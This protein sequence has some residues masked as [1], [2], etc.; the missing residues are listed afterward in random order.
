MI[1]ITQFTLL[2]GVR[3]AVFSDDLIKESNQGV[4]VG[5]KDL[6][7]NQPVVIKFS[8]AFFAGQTAGEISDDKM[9]ILREVETLPILR[10]IT[11]VPYYIGTVRVP[12]G[13]NLE[14]LAL[15]MSRIQGQ[16][17][18]QRRKQ[19]PK[20]RITPQEALDMLNQVAHILY[21]VHER[22]VVHR[23]LKLSNFMVTSAG[24]YAIVDWGTAL[25]TV[26]GK[27]DSM[28]MTPEHTVIGTIQFMSPEQIIGKQV[29]QRTDIYSLGEIVA[30]LRYGPEISQRYTIDS[31]GKVTQRDKKQI[32]K[33]VAA[34][35]TLKYELIPASN[36]PNEKLLQEIIRKMTVPKRED[37]Y[38]TMQEVFT[39]IN[40]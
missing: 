38:Q 20:K 15:V 29:D 27:S 4:A 14:Q 37:R 33:A 24:Q 30:L 21:Q 39:A 5:G 10:N 17:L 19:D 6:S 26:N 22:N 32:A 8:H 36:D 18:E 7:T 12:A 28:W 9:N 35:E 40:H 23:D 34:R 2:T 16:D 1:S 31:A 11:G 13:D 25:H 3:I